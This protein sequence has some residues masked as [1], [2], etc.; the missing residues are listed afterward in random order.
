VAAFSLWLL[1]RNYGLRVFSGEVSVDVYAL[2]DLKKR[3][4]N[5]LSPADI[6]EIF[7]PPSENVKDLLAEISRVDFVVTSKFHGVVFSHL[8]A[9]PVIALS[10][11]NKIDDLMRT[12]GHS[13]YCLNIESFDAERLE[14]AFMSL[15]DNA[16]ELKLKFRGKTTLYSSALKAQFDEVFVPENLQLPFRVPGA[17]R[18]RTIFGGSV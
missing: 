16:Q 6:N 15:V 13:E 5:S 14:S 10:Y 18:K 11:H 4:A 3:L 8:L 7:M 17:A 12:V 2:E 9:K 1:S